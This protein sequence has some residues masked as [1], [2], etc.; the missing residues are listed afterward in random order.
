MPSLKPMKTFRRKKGKEEPQQKPELD[1]TNAL[2]PSDDFRTSLLMTGLSA[3]FSMLREQDDPKSKIGKA[4]DDSV[5]FPKRQSR[6]MDFGFNPKGLSDIAEVGSINESIKR[7]YGRANSI[8]STDDGEGSIMARG[9][10]AEGNNLFGGRQKVYKIPMSA[11]TSMKNITGEGS[12]ALSGRALYEEDLSQSAFQKLRQKEREEKERLES[13]RFS[14]DRTDGFNAR[15]GSPPPFNYNSNRE[16]SSTTSSG[17]GGPRSSTAATSVTS[18]RTPSLSG[19]SAPS[20]PSVPSQ[21]AGGPQEKPVTK[22]KRLYDNGL[23]QHLHSQQST[24]MHRLDTLSRRGPNRPA[25]SVSP[26]SQSP[27]T[28]SS[29][30]SSFKPLESTSGTSGGSVRTAPPPNVEAESGLKSPAVENLKQYGINPPLSPPVSEAADRSSP[31][32]QP[33]DRG[34][35]PGSAP[36]SRPHL[37]YDESKYAQRQLQMHKGREMPPPSKYPPPQ[38]LPPHPPHPQYMGNSQNMPRNRAHSNAVLPSSRPIG[39]PQNKHFKPRPRPEALN[40]ISK[41]VKTPSPASGTFLMN[42]ASESSDD[43][44]RSSEERISKRDAWEQAAAY[45]EFQPQPPPTNFNRPQHPYSGHPALRHRGPQSHGRPSDGPETGG[46]Q[47]RNTEEAVAPFIEVSKPV[48][49]KSAQTQKVEP[50]A[51]SPTLGPPSGLSGMIRQHLR[52]DSATSSIDEPLAP[53]LTP[54]NMHRC[55]SPPKQVI[56]SAFSHGSQTNGFSEPRANTAADSGESASKTLSQVSDTPSWEK[57]I[58]AH[59]SR[60]GSTETQKERDD[61]ASELAARRKR[62]Q[63]NLRSFAESESRSQSPAPAPHSIELGDANYPKNHLNFLKAKPSRGSLVGKPKENGQ[64]QSKA[65]KMLGLNN[66]SS[67]NLPGQGMSRL[68]EN[69]WDKEE[70]EMLNSV[71]KLPKEAQTSSFRQARREAQRERERQVL[72]RHKQGIGME[73]GNESDDHTRRPRDRTLPFRQADYSRERHPSAAPNSRSESRE[74]PPVSFRRPA[75]HSY[76]GKYSGPSSVA[77]NSRPPTRDR[78]S[79]DISVNGRQ[80][81]HRANVDAS[82]TY[83]TNSIATMGSPSLPPTTAIPPIPTP[84]SRPPSSSKSQ[85]FPNY[86]DSHHVSNPGTPSIREE[87]ASPSLRPSPVAPYAVN[88]TP[89]L[90]HPTST[91]Q[92]SL[93]ASSFEGFQPRAPA[94]RKRS[95]NKSD[96][97]EPTLVSSTSRM[98]TIDLPTQTTAGGSAPPLPPMDPRRRAAS[99]RNIFGWKGKGGESAA[100]AQTSPAL[101]PHMLNHDDITTTSA[102]EA[103]LMKPKGGRNLRKISSEGGNLN[104]RTKL[105]YGTAQSSGVSAYQPQNAMPMTKLPVEGGMF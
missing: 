86:F 87:V 28:Q 93:P 39:P 38:M 96:I 45:D 50:P 101:P 35:V 72:M 24:A 80:R 104:G 82:S 67:S 36:Q 53:G 14:E 6:L 23:D 19:H 71:S 88:S 69:Q 43:S 7:P 21:P 56:G 66:S 77:S 25:A 5:L 63:E 102:D 105:V 16:T 22:P 9:K 51:D 70:E 46:R 32:K 15:A 31:F 48:D 61:F 33:N 17:P 54:F 81:G 91:V 83:G 103:E 4:S 44:P 26:N 68:D 84:S 3:R 27:Q 12:G 30:Q 64:G 58:N 78:S 37:P 11:S 85:A 90:V 74:A 47:R 98:T 79:S 95:V 62:V 65:M 100:S 20:T 2:P 41:P 52:S 57:E 18:Q 76:D 29:D 49:V 1:L 73:S 10:P 34:K 59:H 97:S 8:H 99:T 75:E 60:D 55:G 13:F 89:A 94:P 92:T 42:S 40:P